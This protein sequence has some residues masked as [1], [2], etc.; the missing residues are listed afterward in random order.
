MRQR[1]FLHIKN[2]RHLSQFHDRVC[3]GGWSN[4]RWDLDV[5]VTTCASRSIMQVHKR[6]IQILH[7]RLRKDDHPRWRYVI[8]RLASLNWMTEPRE[9]SAVSLLVSLRTRGCSGKREIHK[10]HD[11][12]GR[13]PCDNGGVNQLSCVDSKVF[14]VI[15]TDAKNEGGS[16]TL[17]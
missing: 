3:F 2:S 16:V 6:V 9:A 8:K 12:K 10:L 15:A 5:L 7:M 4:P 14:I 17:S 1:H 13:A 11:S